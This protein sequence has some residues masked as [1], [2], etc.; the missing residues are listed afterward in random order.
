MIIDQPLPSPR[1]RS[2]RWRGRCRPLIVGAASTGVAAVA[3]LATAG[4]ADA[5]PSP[6]TVA[7]TAASTSWAHPCDDGPW[8]VAG[9]SVEGSPAGFDAGDVGR[10]YLWH[11]GDGWHLRTTDARPG[12]H[13]Y[14]GTITTSPGASFVD[15]GKVKLDP[16]DVLSVDDQH[17]LHY[18]FTTYQGIDGVN[19]R[20]SA[21]DGDRNHERL[22]F[23][24]R[25]E[26]HDDDPGLVD[27]G[28]HRA[29]PGADPFVA[30]RSV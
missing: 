19:F 9:A 8:R 13:H 2:P 14:S 4:V 11:D 25:K 1:K 6:A 30:H 27:L 12:P 17:V 24:L 29:H 23:A 26:G 22:T 10:T 5:A 20:V 21:C 18:A 28:A 3:A 7:P 16:G 15:V